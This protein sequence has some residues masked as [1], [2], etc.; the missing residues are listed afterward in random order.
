MLLF[1]SNKYHSSTKHSY[2]SIRLYPNRVDWNNP[3]NRFKY[4]SNNFKRVSLSKEED[5]FDFL[6]LI[7]GIT[8]K[9]TYPGMEYYLRVNPSAGALY[10]NEI[11]FQVRNEKYLEDGIYHFEVGT[12]NVTLLKKLKVNEGIE[13]NLELDYS[14]DGFIFL[15]SSIYYRSSWKYKNRAFRYCLLDAGHILGTIEAS[16][17]IYNKS[18]NVCSDFD[19]KSLNEIFNF[20]EKEFFTSYVIASNNKEKKN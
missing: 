6:Y 11:Y 9:K 4:Y 17:Y 8:A 19:K 16:C 18:F 14:Y 10:P 12:S 5:V 20:D 15:I 3:P 7:A 2:N 1:H 13:G